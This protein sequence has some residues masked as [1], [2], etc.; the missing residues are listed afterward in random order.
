MHL[1]HASHIVLSHLFTI[2]NPFFVG[3]RFCF[4]VFFFF[5][6][7]SSLAS[8]F[9]EVEEEKEEIETVLGPGE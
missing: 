8:S 1:R 6:S 9:A 2:F 4:F 5:S 7:S 3:W